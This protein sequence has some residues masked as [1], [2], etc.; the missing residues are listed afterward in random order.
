MLWC[1]SRPRVIVYRDILRE[2]KKNYKQSSRP[3]LRQYS[4]TGPGCC[5]A[6]VC[7]SVCSLNKVP[8]LTLSR[9]HFK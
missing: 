4:R 3:G 6:H 5:T 9:V 2:L 7:P 8:A 1:V